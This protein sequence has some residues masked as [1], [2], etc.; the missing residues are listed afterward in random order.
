VREG[1]YGG[2]ERRDNNDDDISKGKNTAQQKAKQQCGNE[3]VVTF[4]QWKKTNK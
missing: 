2:E 1:N 4:E 3:I